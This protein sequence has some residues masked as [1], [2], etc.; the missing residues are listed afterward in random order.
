METARVLGWRGGEFYLNFKAYKLDGVSF[1]GWRQR[2]EKGAVQTR[3][4]V[5]GDLMHFQAAHKPSPSPPPFNNEIRTK[6]S[7]WNLAKHFVR[8]RRS[9]SMYMCVTWITLG[10]R[11]ILLL[12]G[13]CL[14]AASLSTIIPGSTSIPNRRMLSILIQR[15][16]WWWGKGTFNGI[17]C[18]CK[19][20]NFRYP[21]KVIPCRDRKYF[22]VNF[23]SN[24][25]SKDFPYVL[26]TRMNVRSSEELSAK[27]NVFCN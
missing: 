25:C 20:L 17:Y 16:L 8:D 11:P 3:D 27:R 5:V 4:A 18:G 2:V 19:L 14:I 10:F 6:F 24:F 21:S 23:L 12:S 9:D 15:K 22:P 26:D 13:V 7:G 1:A